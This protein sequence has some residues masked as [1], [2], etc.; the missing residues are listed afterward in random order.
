MIYK[1]YKNHLTAILYRKYVNL[2][3]RDHCPKF[4]ISPFTTFGKTRATQ[5]LCNNVVV[6][7][8]L[9]LATPCINPIF[10][11]MLKNIIVGTCVGCSHFMCNEKSLV[12]L[13][14]KLLCLQA[15]RIDLFNSISNETK[16]SY[17]GEKDDMGDD[18]ASLVE[19]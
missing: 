6:F 2:K 13:Q 4:R 18:S 19:L 7:K 8:S 1:L 9:N 5:P 10:Y 3:K 15:G 14:S 12:V 11:G 17:G 16:T